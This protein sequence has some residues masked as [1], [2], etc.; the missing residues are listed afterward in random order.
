MSVDTNFTG[1][2]FLTRADGLRT[3]ARDLTHLTVYFLTCLEVARQ[4]RRLL[5]L[6]TQALKDIGVSRADAHREATRGFWDIPD[7][8]MRRD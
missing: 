2:V 1:R 8:V 5:T 6:D 3:L 4:R 7:D